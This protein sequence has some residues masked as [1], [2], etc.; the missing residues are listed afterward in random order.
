MKA[1]PERSRPAKESAVMRDVAASAASESAMQRCSGRL[2]RP[3][4][5]Q[6]ANH[7]AKEG[8]TICAPRARYRE[9]S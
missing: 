9:I 7:A 1:V 3:I 5:R 4:R 2:A 6:V 8:L